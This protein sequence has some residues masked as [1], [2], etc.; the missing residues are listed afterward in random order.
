MN[1]ED[2][3]TSTQTDFVTGWQKL[4]TDEKNVGI[5]SVALLENLTVGQISAVAAFKQLQVVVKWLVLVGGPWCAGTNSKYQHYIKSVKKKDLPKTWIWRGNRL[6]LQTEKII[7]KSLS[8]LQ[9]KKRWTQRFWKQQ[10]N[11]SPANSTNMALVNCK[12]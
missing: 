1:L 2:H 12:N 3:N 5:E 10:I 4:E 6:K 11:I 9:K 8:T 7:E